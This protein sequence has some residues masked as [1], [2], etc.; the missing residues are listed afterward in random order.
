M[1]TRNELYEALKWHKVFK[2]RPFVSSE[3]LMSEF[4]EEII[5]EAK[6]KYPR[7]KIDTL[8]KAVTLLGYDYVQSKKIPYQNIQNEVS[9][10]C[11]QALEAIEPLIKDLAN[12]AEIEHSEVPLCFQTV[13]ESLYLSQGFGAKTYAEGH[14]KQ[15]K[16]HVESQ[17]VR[18][19][20]VVEGTSSR[21]GGVFKCMAYVKEDVDLEIIRLRDTVTLREWIKAC[22]KMGTNPRVYQPFLP[23]GLEEKLGIDYFGG[24]K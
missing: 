18:A 4:R 9:S 16:I 17:G 22:W 13:H 21:G 23:V 24:D 14:A 6:E 15:A 19:E 5:G 20:V 11:K 2:E 12:R 7:R 10:Q 1:G 3:Q 8:S